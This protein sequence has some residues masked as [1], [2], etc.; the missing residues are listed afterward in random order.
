MTTNKRSTRQHFSFR[1]KTITLA[2]ALATDTSIKQ[3]STSSCQRPQKW[4][5]SQIRPAQ[6]VPPQRVDV[7]MA[8]PRCHVRCCYFWG[9]E[10]LPPHRTSL[11]KLSGTYTKISCASQLVVFIYLLKQPYRPW[12]TWHNISCKNNLIEFVSRNWVV[13]WWHLC[14]RWAV[15]RN[16]S[17]VSS[18]SSIRALSVATFPD[19]TFYHG[20]T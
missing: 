5:S 6:Q 4:R 17:L 19:H 1:N 14:N 10:L 12:Q 11:N 9:A 7:A 15:F 3:I 13:A 2:A 8:A 18:I 20:L 16:R